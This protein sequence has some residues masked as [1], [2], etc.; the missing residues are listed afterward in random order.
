MCISL[1]TQKGHDLWKSLKNS[2]VLKSNKATEYWEPNVNEKYFKRYFVRFLDK[3][4]GVPQS[5]SAKDG[6]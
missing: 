5:I 2:G 6:Y 4:K 1:S 3:L